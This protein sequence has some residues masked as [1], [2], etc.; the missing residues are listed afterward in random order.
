L[1]IVNK[2]KK[3]FLELHGKEVKPNSITWKDIG[4]RIGT[5]GQ[6]A[7]AIWKRY[8]NR[9]KTSLKK[10]PKIIVLDIETTPNKA[11]TWKIWQENI[12]PVNGQL[13]QDWMV[14]S[15]AIKDLFEDNKRGEV[16]TPQEVRKKDDS[17]LLKLL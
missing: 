5:T 1:T 3:L 12:N 9:Q 2:L 14:L 6:A 7:K 15:Y 10:S 16:L 11:F 4:P 8:R 13:I 17:R